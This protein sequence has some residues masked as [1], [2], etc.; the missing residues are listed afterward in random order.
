M[1]LFLV[2]LII[3]VLLRFWDLDLRPIHHDEAVNGWFVDGLL[4]RG[5]YIYDPENYHG[6][7]FFYVLALFEKVFG[8]SLAS[9][10]TPAV[11]FGAALTF[12]PLFFRK[13]IGSRA[14]WISIAVLTLSPAVVFFSRYSIHETAFVFSCILFLRLWLTVRESPSGTGLWV[15]LGLSLG[16]MASL[17]ENFV[18]FG[19]ALGLAELAGAVQD[20]RMGFFRERRFWRG[21]VV[22]FGVAL[23]MIAVVFT[24]G[25]QDGDGFG[26][27]F[28]AFA[29]WAGTGTKGNGH[30]KPFLYWVEL[31]GRFEWPVFA[32]LI[33]SFVVA[34]R[35]SGFVRLN[36]WIGIF[37]W[38]VYSLV[39]YKT[40]WCILSL[41]FFPT[42]AFG[43]VVD[44]TLLKLESGKKT[45]NKSSL[46][47]RNVFAGLLVAGGLF[48]GYRA[49]E[50][51]WLSPDQDGH[52]Y[53]YG[54]T[55]RDF[56]GPV[57]K[58]LA[59]VASMPEGKETT[60]IQVLSRF[61]WPLPYLLGE[62]K[63]AGYY[64]ESNAP[65][66]FNADFV[67]M[68]EDLLPKYE[69]RLKGRYEREVVR[70]R[71]WSSRMVFMSKT[72]D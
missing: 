28:L 16:L 48:S 55:Y 60:R 3:L 1:K 37:S 39:A 12:A 20:R 19:A 11:L 61:T 41:L 26:K 31:M 6:P 27:F 2:P 4:T 40:P 72:G 45:K 44:K 14:A 57:H 63:Q 62:I 47:P 17:K 54:Q 42:L 24:G 52:P 8:R 33:A 30:E 25:F 23:L 58:I 71:Q 56:L 38:L 9:L 49:F 10:R 35:D 32:G 13:W 59:K 29:K 34:V 51:S 36:A 64:G 43:V 5:Y 7:F 70:A 53:I 50:V 18:V 65:A 21:V 46:L 66:E 68:D 69:S 22:C 67:L 15:I